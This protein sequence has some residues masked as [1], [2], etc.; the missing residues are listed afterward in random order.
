MRP[1]AVGRHAEESGGAEWAERVMWY[2]VYSIQLT[3][4][5]GE[6]SEQGHYSDIWKDLNWKAN[7]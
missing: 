2:T 6:D 3:V 7:G 1:A 5:I 4:K